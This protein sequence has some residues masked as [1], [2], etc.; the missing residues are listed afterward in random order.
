VTLDDI[1]ISPAS[2][3]AGTYDNL[4]MDLTAKT[5]RYIED[6]GAGAHASSKKKPGGST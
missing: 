6:E 4:T 3:K 1:Q 5:Y 2:D